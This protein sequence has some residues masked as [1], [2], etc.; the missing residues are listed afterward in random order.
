MHLLLIFEVHPKE[1]RNNDR[2]RIQ[3]PFPA[4]SNK[5]NTRLAGLRSGLYAGNDYETT[6]DKF[7]QSRN[8]P[9]EFQIRPMAK[10]EAEETPSEALIKKVGQRV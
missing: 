5:Q 3:Y 8:A 9:Q 10:N 7:L 2:G 4:T 6:T 1:D